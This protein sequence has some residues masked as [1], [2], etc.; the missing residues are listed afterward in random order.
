MVFISSNSIDFLLFRAILDIVSVHRIH[1]VIIIE[2][3]T[4]LIQVLVDEDVL[5][6][7]VRRLQH[8]LQPLLMNANIFFR[9]L[10][11]MRC[12]LSAFVWVFIGNYFTFA[13]QER[14]TCLRLTATHF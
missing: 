9:G 3:F 4:V 2:E 6:I 7:I 8:I 5:H 11:R 10:H 1:V 12:Y 13:F 14:C